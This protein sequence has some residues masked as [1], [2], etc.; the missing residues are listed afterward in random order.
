MTYKYIYIYIYI[1]QFFVL[2]VLGERVLGHW[3]AWTF[4][5]KVNTSIVIGASNFSFLGTVIP[6][7]ARMMKKVQ[8][9]SSV[10]YQRLTWDALRKSIN[11]VV[12]KVNA[13]NVKNIIPEFFSENLIRGRTL[14]CRSCMKSQMA[15]P[16]FTDV[17]AALISLRI[18]I[19]YVMY[20]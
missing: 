17:F 19:P 2:L 5:A 14:F 20:S 16:G 13:A 9:K 4:K 10:E 15:S 18:K 1:R 3:C 11:G 7:L 8:D 12:N 6:T